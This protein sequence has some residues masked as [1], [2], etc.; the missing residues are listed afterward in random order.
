M[1][2]DSE[3]EF[4]IET[5]ED[6][7]EVALVVRSHSGKKITQEEFIVQIEMYLNDVVNAEAY[8]RETGASVH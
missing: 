1:I 4:M 3:L 7:T 5:N 8:K 6:D 2:D